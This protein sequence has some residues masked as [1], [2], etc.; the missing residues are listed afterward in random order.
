MVRAQKNSTMSY[1]NSLSNPETFIYIHKQAHSFPLS[2]DQIVQNAARKPNEYTATTE[3]SN[4]I[5]CMVA[6]ILFYCHV[7]D[8]QI[9]KHFG[10][11]KHY[12]SSC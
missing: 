11:L 2:N 3:I 10:D 12:Q 8:G 7:S 4:A 9:W 5:S 1:K 6:E